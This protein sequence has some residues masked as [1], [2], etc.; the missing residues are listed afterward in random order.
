M[1]YVSITFDDGRSDNFE[2]AYPILKDK[3]FPATLF[4]TTGYVDGSWQKEKS[5]L[6]TESA[7]SV[8]DMKKLR[9]SG[10]EIALHGDRHDMSVTDTRNALT[11]LSAWGFDCKRVGCSVPNSR[12]SESE[13]DSI[14]K[15]DYGSAIQYIRRGRK[16]NTKRFSIRIL[17]AVYTYTNCA[18]AFKAFNQLNYVRLP[19]IIHKDIPSIVIRTSDKSKMISDFIRAL[20]DNTF[21]VLMFHSILPESH[22]LYGK[23]PWCWSQDKFSNL[24]CQLQHMQT[25]GDVSVSTMMDVIECSDLSAKGN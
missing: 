16:C 2:Y 14:L 25:N 12:V 6:S 18:W 24:C 7:L 23:D 22:P 13:I 8:E 15:S 11:K 19:D 21:L 9:D 3:G 1:K 5:W 10:W 17:Y 4:C 20:P